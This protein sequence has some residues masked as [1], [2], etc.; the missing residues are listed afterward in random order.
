M[1]KYFEKLRLRGE[2]KLREGRDLNNNTVS[3]GTEEFLEAV[4][5]GNVDAVFDLRDAVLLTKYKTITEKELVKLYKHIKKHRD[6]LTKKNDYKKG[7]ALFS[8]KELDAPRAK[9]ILGRFAHRTATVSLGNTLMRQ[10]AE[11][12]DPE[13]IS[14]MI[15]YN[16]TNGDL[17]DESTARI[18]HPGRFYW[19]NVFYYAALGIAFD[20]TVYYPNGSLE[21]PGIYGGIRVGEIR[22]SSYRKLLNTLE[23]FADPELV[24]TEEF[25]KRFGDLE[26]TEE[27]IMMARHWFFTED[28]RLPQSRELRAYR[29]RLADKLRARFAPSG[30]TSAVREERHAEDRAAADKIPTSHERI[31]MKSGDVYEGEC[32]NGE[33]HG[34]GTYTSRKG[35]IYVGMFDNGVMTDGK[36]TFTAS[37]STFEGHFVNGSLHGHGK[38]VYYKEESG[39]YVYSATYEGEWMSGT[40]CGQGT[41]VYANGDTYSGEWRDGKLNGYGKSDTYT[42]KYFSKLLIERSYEGYWKD[43][44][45]HGHGVEKH[46]FHGVTGHTDVEEGEW[47]NGSKEGRFVWQTVYSDGHTGKKYLYWY[48]NGKSL[49]YLAPYD[50]NAITYEQIRRLNDQKEAEEKRACEER[51]QRETAEQQRKREASA[52][53]STVPCTTVSPDGFVLKAMP[54][55]VLPMELGSFQFSDRT[56]KTTGFGAYSDSA[57]AQFGGCIKDGKFSGFGFY[58]FPN[59]SEWYVGEFSNGQFNGYGV[60]CDGNWAHFGRF[61]DGICTTE[62]YFIEKIGRR[63]T[64]HNNLYFNSRDDATISFTENQVRMLDNVKS[65][66][67]WECRFDINSMILTVGKFKDDI[68]DPRGTVLY[69]S[70]KELKMF[71][72][73]IVKGKPCGRGYLTSFDGVTAEC[74]IYGDDVRII[75]RTDWAGRKI[76]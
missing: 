7:R 53:S 14:Y 58:I 39:R 26:P 62:R 22:E 48:E 63:P 68:N 44:K 65:S 47:V 40:Y 5:C 30:G 69:A 67:A 11:N 56:S 46:Y 43:N 8:D 33:Y 41:Y 2:E 55:V 59:S 15:D 71:V 32:A 10:A 75:S 19:D 52:R 9:C 42:D 13:A 38:A 51:R 66:S 54:Q 70:P 73:N 27:Q 37:G 17:V 23:F 74:E 64:W 36:L 45:K 72:G 24:G 4:M 35:W 57:G 21:Y 18:L 50:E 34:R 16:S 60:Y 3:S 1:D 76:D 25:K 49:I 6:K 28:E 12:G 29:E 20:Y 61:E 31:V